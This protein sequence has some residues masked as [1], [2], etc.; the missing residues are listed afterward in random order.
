MKE[1]C[2]CIIGYELG[3]SHIDEGVWIEEVKKS[4]INNRHKYNLLSHQTKFCPNCGK[5]IKL[6]KNKR[7]LWD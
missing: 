6:S 4:Y 5:R 1:D 2:D 7:K 3:F